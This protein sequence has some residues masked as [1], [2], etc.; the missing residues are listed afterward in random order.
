MKTIKYIVN[1]GDKYNNLTVIDN[2]LR[3]KHNQ[4]LLLCK[5]DCGND[6]KCM[7]YS[8]IFGNTKSCG[9]LKSARLKSDNT[10]I[11]IGSKIGMITIINDYGTYSQSGKRQFQIKCDC[12]TIKDINISYGTK[13]CGCLKRK[14]LN[15]EKIEY[16][17]YK[18]SCNKRKIKFNLTLEEYSILIKSNCYYCDNK[19]NMK[20]H[21]SKLLK[22]GIDRI[23]NALGYHKDNCVSCCANCNYAKRKLTF[24]EF[25]DMIKKI[26]LKHLD[27]KHP[28]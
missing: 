15:P 14:S 21:V 23:N 17:R 1:V 26:Y 28:V 9:C 3:N 19:P 22:N 5:C 25:M 13:S 16:E 18:K 2:S 10:K 24:N 7:P 11:G 4:R 12:G 6:V 20:M 8:L 27:F